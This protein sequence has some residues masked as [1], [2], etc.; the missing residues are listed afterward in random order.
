LKSATELLLHDTLLAK[1]SVTVVRTHDIPDHTDWFR[2]QPRCN[3]Q[4]T[5]QVVL[6]VIETS[7]NLWKR[8]HNIENVRLSSDLNGNSGKS[9]VEGY[10]SSRIIEQSRNTEESRR[11]RLNRRTRLGRLEEE[12]NRNE[13][14][15]PKGGG[16][17]LEVVEFGEQVRRPWRSTVQLVKGVIDTFRNHA[18][19]SIPREDAAEW[20]LEVETLLLK[21]ILI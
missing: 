20:S 17:K 10:R 14:K 7:R 9:N 13:E 21:R 11:R 8:P 4:T 5:V 12:G 19:V 1:D 6:D 3:F 2:L 18:T 15:Q 16:R